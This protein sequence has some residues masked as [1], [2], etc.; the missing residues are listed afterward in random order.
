MIGI[1]DKKTFCSLRGG[2]VSELGSQEQVHYLH[3]RKSEPGNCHNYLGL[4][5]KLR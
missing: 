5:Y 1:L 2:E 4:R 3:S